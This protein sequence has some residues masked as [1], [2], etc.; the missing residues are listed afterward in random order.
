MP[1]ITRTAPAVVLAIPLILTCTFRA[2]GGPPPAAIPPSRVSFDTTELTL[3]AAL[4]A[5]EKQ[6]GLTVT[7]GDADPARPC[8]V[9]AVKGKPF[10]DVLAGLATATG[11]RVVVGREGRQISFA[12]PTGV[13]PFVST[14]GPF[15]FTAREVTGRTDLQTGRTAYDLTLDT[16]WEPRFPV[17]RI[18]A[19]PRITSGTDDL[20][21]RLSAPASSVKSQVTGFAHTTAVRIDGLTRKSGKIATLAGEFTV[22]ASP[23]M[24]PVR[25]D[26]L[27]ALPAEKKMEGVTVKLVRFAKEEDRWETEL[28][29][30]Y[31]PGQPEFESF[32]SWA[33]G[34]TLKL[35]APGTGRVFTP[36]NYDLTESS[37]RV[38]AAYRFRTA[39]GKGPDVGDRK[40]WQLVYETPAPLVEYPVRFAF[41][42]IPLP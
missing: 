18:D 6:T 23:R 7:P 30:T 12:K 16:S 37:R 36:D 35:V 9:A 3:A 5:I 29:L 11:T 8:P 1:G 14:D 17:F 38:R 39:G 33:S 41:K 22:T 25:F 26:D 13:G 21:R 2:P 34:N 31:P 32:E 4:A 27:A 15:R 40:G 10:W 42:D 24:L 28:D 19:R 20:G